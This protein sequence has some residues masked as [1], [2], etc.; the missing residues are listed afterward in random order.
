MSENTNTKTAEV[1]VVVGRFQCPYIH[2]GYKYL[3]EYVA[4]RH[5]RVFV[6]LGQTA[7]A[8]RCSFTDP[9]TFQ[10]RAR[11]IQREYPDFEIYKIDDL[12]NPPKW[13]KV[14]DSQIDLLAGP[15]QKAVLYGSR[16]SFLEVYK[17]RNPTQEVPSFGGDVSATQIRRE[18]GI[19]PLDDEKFRIGVAWATQNQ[20]TTV[21][22]VVDMAAIDV[23][24]RVLIGR[25]ETDPPD[26]YRFPGGFVSDS[27]SFEDDAYRELD[28]ETG[29][30]GTQIHYVTSR[31]IDDA[32]FKNQREKI[33]SI[34]YAITQ[35]NG[36][37][38]PADDLSGGELKWVYLNKLGVLDMFP[39]HRWL[40]SELVCWWDKKQEIDAALKMYRCSKSKKLA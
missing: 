16:D 9:Y 10:M 14:L 13:S 35:W 31:R 20:W 12:G 2:E 6:F 19:T 8:V 24:G 39:Q 15:G 4:S 29:L 22:T 33:K 7:P 36:E 25:R 32:R 11:M 30:Q 37:P 34:F 5:K 27:D 21:K 23:E 18:C 1:A 40:L 3:F 17:G 28:E 38:K 26:Q